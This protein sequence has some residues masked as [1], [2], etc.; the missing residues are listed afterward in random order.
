M[1]SL[2]HP[3]LHGRRQP[4]S[5][6]K[7]RVLRRRQLRRCYFRQALN[8]RGAQN[9]QTS[10]WIVGRPARWDR[11]L[12]KDCRLLCSRPV[13]MT[14]QARMTLR[15]G[16]G[17]LVFFAIA[18]PGRAQDDVLSGYRKYYSGDRAGAQVVLERLLATNPG[19]LPVR[20]GLLHISM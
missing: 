16:A 15:L 7:R 2:R 4:E 6:E 13:S 1:T 19:S 20:F 11:S 17:L 14:L 9:L 5:G 8:L 12:R 10:R 18:S 3:S